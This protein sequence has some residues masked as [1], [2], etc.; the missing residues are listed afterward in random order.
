MTGFSRFGV[1]PETLVLTSNGHEKI[2]T[3]AGQE[4]KIWNGLEFEDTSV[5]KVAE[6]VKILRVTV[7]T[8]Q[9]IECSEDHVFIHQL[10][11]NKVP[12][13]LLQTSELETGMRL[14]KSPT[15]PVIETGDKT[16]P[17]AYTHGFYMGM[18]RYKRRRLVISRASIFG[19]RRPI[20]EHL[21]LDTSISDRH[22]LHL[23]N[24]LPADFE[25]PFESGYSL[26]TR[27]EWLAGLLDGGAT[28]RKPTPKPIWQISSSNRDFL[29]QVKLL[30]QTLGGDVRVLET[31]E[32]LAHQYT[33]NITGAPMQT[34]SKLS[35]PVVRVKIPKHE[36][37]NRGLSGP[38]IVSVEDAY[39]TS[40]VYNF[41][42]TEAKM[43]I[44]NGLYTSSN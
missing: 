17:H 13:E 21:E 9:E 10:A 38:K 7:D 37:S 31:G 15:F 43:A 35:I 33:L 40:D 8:G 18:E 23:V 36:Y 3:L 19:A 26:E 11:T 2:G 20:L 28:L 4:V 42:G 32:I 24:T 39:R 22:S 27:L 29:Q 12:I 30:T 14:K 5:F 1:T 6:N 34:L 16:Y 41:I 44:F 25:A